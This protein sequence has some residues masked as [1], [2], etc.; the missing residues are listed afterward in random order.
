MRRW[1]AVFLAGFVA[2]AVIRG[3]FIERTKRVE[4]VVSRKDFA[5]LAVMFAVFLGSILLPLLY[6][7]TPWLRF[8]DVAPP[9]YLP[10]CGL[11]CMLAALWLFWRAHADLGANWSQ[12]LE[13]RKGHT[14]VQHGVYARIRHPMYSAIWLFGLAQGLMLAN[15]LAGW[16]AIAGFSLMYFIRTPR[17]EALMCEVFGDEYRDYMRRTGRLLPR[18]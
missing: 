10:W 14:L 2:Y 16:S 5:E 13:V 8:A 1:D 7:F 6:L 18:R 12:T 11:A 4:K 15:W 3:V 9:P 17:E